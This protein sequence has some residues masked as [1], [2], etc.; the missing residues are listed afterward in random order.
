[1]TKDE[2]SAWALSHGW[3]VRGGHVSLSRPSAPSEPI[4][5]LVFKATV[6]ALEF[7]KPAGKWEKMGGAAYGA[8]HPD[9]DTGVPRGLGL[10][11][12]AG[13]SS[14]MQENSDRLAFSGMGPAPKRP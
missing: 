5:R 9:P 2:V 6:V 14:L 13:L 3:R 1:V 12:I 11:S 10:V 4:V 7:R 8:V